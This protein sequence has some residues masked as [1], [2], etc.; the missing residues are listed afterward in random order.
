MEKFNVLI[1]DDMIA[2]GGSIL[3][4]AKNMKERGAKRVFLVSTFALFTEG[5]EKFDEYYENKIISG[6]YSTNLSHISKEFKKSKW[7]HIVDLSETISEIIYML[8]N[9]KSISNLLNGKGNA[10]NKIK[11]I[12]KLK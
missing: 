1:V 4:C 2:S 12:R 8:S 7:L 10:V 3:E 11:S 9:G 5:T 6:V